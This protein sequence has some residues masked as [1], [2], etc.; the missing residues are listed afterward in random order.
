VTRNQTL[1]IIGLTTAMLAAG[2][3]LAQYEW[4]RRGGGRNRN[5][6]Y[7]DRFVLDD[8]KGVPDWEV[9]PQFKSDVFTFVRVRYGGWGGRRG[10]GGWA[11]DYPDIKRSIGSMR[12]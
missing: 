9:D 10:R 1:A 7:D 2:I 3:V 6:D 4:E 12:T 11:T 5:R 8:R